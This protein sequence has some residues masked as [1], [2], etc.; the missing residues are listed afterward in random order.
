MVIFALFVA[1]SII[2][3]PVHV[4]ARRDRFKPLAK[5][6]SRQIEIFE[7]PFDAH[8]EKA[9]LVILVLIG[10]QDI[11]GMGIEEIGNGG[12]QAFPVGTINQ[13]NGSVSCFQS[14]LRV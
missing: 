1:V 6:F 10:M 14:S 8:E 13:Q 5:E 11:G 3:T 9:Q 4:K 2:F 12:H 7:R